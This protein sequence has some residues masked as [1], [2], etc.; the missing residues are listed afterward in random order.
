MHAVKFCVYWQ[1]SIADECLT[2][3]PRLWSKKSQTLDA[4]YL[5]ENTLLSLWLR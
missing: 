4:L 5:P 2:W 3:L 1:Y